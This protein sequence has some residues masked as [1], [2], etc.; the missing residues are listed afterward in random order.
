MRRSRP[1]ETMIAKTLLYGAA[2]V[3][4]LGGV[5]ALTWHTASLHFRLEQVVED[6][7]TVLATVDR[8]LIRSEG[9]EHLLLY[10]VDQEN[11]ATRMMSTKEGFCYLLGASS[12]DRRNTV[13][14]L[15]DSGFWTLTIYGPIDTSTWGLASCSRLRNPKT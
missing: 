11:R 7:E 1:L 3:A 6:T 8:A 14:I 4:I 5:A 2:V 12:I 10:T 15:P 13:L 9:N